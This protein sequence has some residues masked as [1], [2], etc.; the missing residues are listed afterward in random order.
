MTCPRCGASGDGKFCSSCGAALVAPEC[1]S[2][3]QQ[4]QAGARFCNQC[5]GSLA[6]DAGQG[7]APATSGSG[8]SATANMG[9]WIAGAL[10]AGLILVVAWPI[11]GPGAQTPPASSAQGARAVDASSVDLTSMTPRQ[12]ADRLFERVMRAVSVGNQGEILSFLPMA[13]AAYERAAPL[14]SDGSHHLATLLREAQRSEEALAV[15]AQALESAPDHLLVLSSAAEASV[16]LGDEDGARGYYQ[17]LLDVWDDEMAKGLVDY[18][19]AHPA[20]MPMI[21]SAA[22]DFLSGG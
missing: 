7:A 6:S 17:H 11:Y 22:E 21:R 12:A 14:D 18:D 2:C 5:G 8:D 10:L 13:I 16:A 4:S 19:V 20:L 15:A 1:P 3:G 9:W